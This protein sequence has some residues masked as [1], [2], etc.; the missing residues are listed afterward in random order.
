MYWGWALGPT[1]QQGPFA[2]LCSGCP[3][4]PVSLHPPLPPC[5]RALPVSPDPAVW[6]HISL[7]VLWGQEPSLLLLRSQESE[8]DTID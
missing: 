3:P 4:F 7:T 2:F 5:P 1:D 6:R 8:G